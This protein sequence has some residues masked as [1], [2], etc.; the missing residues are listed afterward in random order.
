MVNNTHRYD[1][2]VFDDG[3]YEFLR[4]D[5]GI[6]NKYNAVLVGTHKNPYQ[7]EKREDFRW[8]K[9]RFQNGERIGLFAKDLHKPVERSHVQSDITRKLAKKRNNS[10]GHLKDL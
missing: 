4:E 8:I 3:S 2:N 10:T 5:S 1:T 9:Q 7:S 6:G